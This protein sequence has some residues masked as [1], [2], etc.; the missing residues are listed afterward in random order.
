M[1]DTVVATCRQATHRGPEAQGSALEPSPYG[2][3]WPEVADEAET[4]FVYEEEPHEPGAHFYF[5]LAY[6]AE[7]N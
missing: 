7:G 3:G 1:F 4:S 5:P 6:V 2:A